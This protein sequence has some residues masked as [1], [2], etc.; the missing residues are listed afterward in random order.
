MKPLHWIVLSQDRYQAT[1]EKEDQIYTLQWIV[2]QNV[3]SNAIHAIVIYG[4]DATWKR[5]VHAENI[6]QLMYKLPDELK[7]VHE[8]T[9]QI[10]RTF[11]LQS[12]AAL[13]YVQR[14]QTND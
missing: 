12:N 9:K 13:N 2:R 4:Q 5:T 14:S 10:S 7:T 6:V 3:P 1:C 11:L 8:Q